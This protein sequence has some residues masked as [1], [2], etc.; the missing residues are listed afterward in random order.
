MAAEGYVALAAPSDAPALEDTTAALRALLGGL[1]L[2]FACSG[3]LAFG[4]FGEF[5]EFGE[6]SEFGEFG[7]FAE[8]GEFGAFGEFGEFGEFGVFG[9]F[10][11]F[12]EFGEV[13]QSIRRAAGPDSPS[14]CSAREVPEPVLVKSVGSNVP[15]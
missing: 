9:V 6:L 15:L 4:A 14:D 12:V 7:E 3:V 5:G 10:G 2:E 11:E 1:L 13:G 8:F